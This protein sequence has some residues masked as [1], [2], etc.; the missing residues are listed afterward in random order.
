MIFVVL[1]MHKSGT[2][3]AASLLHESGVPMGEHDPT[4]SYDEGNRYEM[5]EV[6]KLNVDL[7]RGP[8]AAWSL[9]VTRV[10]ELETLEPG[11]EARMGAFV[12]RTSRRWRDWGFKD[13]RTCLTYGAWTRVLPDHRV[14]ATFRHPQE[15]W[16]HYQPAAR[17]SAVAVCWKAL[18]A[19]HVHNRQVLQAVRSRPDRSLVVEY[20]DLMSGD[21]PLEALSRFVGR[22]IADVRRPA[23]Y[24]HRH[25]ESDAVF[26][27]TAA[28]LRR[29]TGRDVMALYDE[30]RSVAV[31]GA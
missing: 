16:R 13:P 21:C 11:L 10:V 28:A 30:L 5:A 4:V 26:R 25:D 27:G 15:L 19:W 7:L 20:G 9:D 29:V 31:R 2:T 1:G 14:I 8:D 23:L 6:R 18:T 3:L 22:A 12:E 17:L 24:R